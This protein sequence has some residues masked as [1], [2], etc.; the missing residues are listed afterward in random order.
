MPPD[1]RRWHHATLTTYGAWLHGDARG[2]RTRQHRE[3]VDGDYE[4]PPPLGKYARREARSRAA[5]SQAPVV[6]PRRM[7]RQ[8]G[9]ALQQKLSRL[10]GWVLCLAVAG[11]HVHLLVKLPPRFARR[12]L[13]Q[14]KKHTTFVMRE[15]RWK[16]KLWGVRCKVTLVRSR[17]QQV[18]TYRYIIRHAAPGA[19]VGIWKKER[20]AIAEL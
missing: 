2:F 17:R 9:L 19:W 8:V 7:R 18:N 16:G 15:Q 11:Q 13:G 14:A 10:G 4:S 3:H 20:G 12:L 1:A 6:I 5:L